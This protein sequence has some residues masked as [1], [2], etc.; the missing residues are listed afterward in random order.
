MCFESVIIGLKQG[1]S[2]VKENREEGS[3]GG[4]SKPSMAVKGKGRVSACIIDSAFLFRKWPA[5]GTSSEMTDTTCS[6][7][8]MKWHGGQHYIK[9]CWYSSSGRC[10]EPAWQI[11]DSRQWR[12]SAICL[13]HNSCSFTTRWDTLPSYVLV[14]K[15]NKWGSL[16]LVNINLPGWF[17]SFRK[18]FDMYVQAK[19]RGW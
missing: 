17:W 5:T 12:K 2:V 1:S 13:H 6:K 11:V 9:R 14:E 18:W 10:T 15:M 3:E 19:K 8:N 7:M 4:R 16:R